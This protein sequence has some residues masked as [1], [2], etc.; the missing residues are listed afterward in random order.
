MRLC[1]EWL[2]GG[3]GKNFTMDFD[4]FGREELRGGER[5][6]TGLFD[7]LVRLIFFISFR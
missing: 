4:D 3:R 7:Y 2:S 1:D 5:V 6:T